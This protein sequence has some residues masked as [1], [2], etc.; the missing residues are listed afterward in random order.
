MPEKLIY[1]V[2]QVL[3]S[4]THRSRFG[5]TEIREK[6]S[7]DS[8]WGLI[9]RSNRTLFVFQSRGWWVINQEEGV[10][11]ARI[12]LAPTLAVVAPALVARCKTAGMTYA[13]LG[14]A[15]LRWVALEQPKA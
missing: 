5:T 1:S 6:P 7:H 2:L 8:L 9:N 15:A 3:C 10:K 12:A 14:G 4:R 11:I 13:V